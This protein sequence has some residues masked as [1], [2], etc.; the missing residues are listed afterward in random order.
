MEDTDLAAEWKF[1]E[2]FNQTKS[3]LNENCKSAAENASKNLTSASPSVEHIK[4][5]AAHGFEASQISNLVES[6]ISNNKISQTADT[7]K[8]LDKFSAHYPFLE[9]YKNEALQGT[10]VT[11]YV[12]SL[13]S[14]YDICFN[15]FNML[16]K[17]WTKKT[18]M[19]K[20][21]N[22][23]GYFGCL[24]HILSC[25]NLYNN[26]MKQNHGVQHL[27][28]SECYSFN[29][30]KLATK[31]KQEET[32]VHLEQLGT[33]AFKTVDVLKA[34]VKHFDVF[35]KDGNLLNY[36]Y[37]YIMNM[38]RLLHFKNMTLATPEQILST[39]LFS[40]IGDIIFDTDSTIS[41]TDIESVVSN[42]NTNIL[43]VL[44]KNTCPDIEIS[45]RFIDE[46]R[47]LLEQ[48]LANVSNGNGAAFE[49]IVEAKVFQLE[50][51]DVLQ[52]VAKR[53][54]LVAFIMGHI[55][56]L[57][58]DEETNFEYCNPGFLRNLLAM[59]EAKVKMELYGNNLTVAALNL[60]YFDVINLQRI[61]KEEKY[62]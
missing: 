46:P 20:L 47:M 1:L 31:L 51:R 56:G 16:P 62:E 60:D 7:L 38:N 36:I 22:Q 6:F 25:V 19:D 10:T 59:N 14:N 23:M 12:L 49:K 40:L 42:L 58:D 57:S 50:R 17:L 39:D 18:S 27:I 44:T 13:T 28:A 15:I 9:L 2:H 24:K 4:Q 45:K 8:I 54:K 30:T 26:Q 41:P 35:K 55:H 37:C 33:D 53:N 34:N 21:D 11:D 32:F 29:P 61:F 3:Q 48:L 5:I 43:H 52:Y